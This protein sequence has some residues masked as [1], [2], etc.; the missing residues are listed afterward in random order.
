MSSQ[1]TSHIY[2]IYD[3]A[4][5]SYAEAVSGT[6]DQRPPRTIVNLPPPSVNSRYESTQQQNQSAGAPYGTSP[7]IVTRGKDSYG[8]CSKC[9]LFFIVIVVIPTVAFFLL[10][11]IL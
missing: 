4:P 1:N 6:F 5:P 7:I 11:R 10:T 9:A 8:T 3:V 2:A